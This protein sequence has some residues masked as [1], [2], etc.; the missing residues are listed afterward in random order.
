MSKKSAASKKKRKFQE[1]LFKE[2]E[3]K[4]YLSKI[5][6]HALSANDKSM[7][8]EFSTKPKKVKPNHA[9]SN[10]QVESDSDSEPICYEKD[11]EPIKHTEKP[12]S[13]AELLA[14][15]KN[16]K[17]E[18]DSGPR[19]PEQ[20]KRQPDYKGITVERDF[21][22]NLK[23]LKLPSCMMEQEIV[24]AIKYNDIVLIT[25]D[26]GTGK[27][28]Q[29]PQ[30]LYENG[31]CIGNTIIGV[32][33]IRRVA[34]IAIANQISLELNS[35]ALVGYQVRYNKG[36]NSKSCKI[37]FMTDGI[38]MNELHTDILCSKY[39]VIIIDEAH[40]RRANCDIL[41]GILSRVVKIRRSRYDNGDSLP[42][43]KLVIMSATIRKEDFLESKIF[44][45]KIK[46]LH[47]LSNAYNC[48]IHYSKKT[49][50]DYVIEARDKVAKIH[51][52]LPPGSILVFLTGKDELHRLRHLLFQI[53]NPSHTMHQNHSATH[54]SSSH[55]DDDDKIFELEAEEISDEDDISYNESD[56]DIFEFNSDE[57]YHNELDTDDGFYQ[58]ELDTMSSNYT[59]LQESKWLG[60]DGSGKLK[61]VILHASQTDKDQMEAF[62]I[63]NDNERIV[64]L[65][66]NVAETSVTLPNIRYVVDTGK[67][68]R[69]VHNPTRGVSNF[70]ICNISKSSAQQRAGR[71]GRVGNGHCYRLYSNSIYETLFDDYSPVE[72]VECNLESNLLFLSSIGIANPYD[73]SFLTPPPVENVDIAMKTLATLGAIEVPKTRDM[74]YNTIHSK[75]TSDPLKISPYYPDLCDYGS[76]KEYKRA[77][78]TKLGRC[79]SLIPMEPRY[80]K[81]I[82]C[83]LSKGKRANYIALSFCIVSAMSFSGGLFVERN[84][85]REESKELPSFSNDIDMLIWLFCKYTQRTTNKVEFCNNYN[86]NQKA[87]GEIFLQAIQVYNILKIRFS[88][89][90]LEHVNW[91]EPIKIPLPE[92]RRWLK[93]S[94]VECLIDKLAIKGAY[95]GSK[96]GGYKCS[97]MPNGA[98]CVYLNNTYSKYKYECVVYN[99]LVGDEKI[100][101]RDVLQAN[102]A[103]VSTIKSPLV[104]SRE[105]Q[106]TPV[107][108]Y[109]KEKDVV[110]VYTKKYYAPLNYYLNVTRVALDHKHPLSIRIFAQHFCFGLVYGRIAE[111]S[112][113]LAVSMD[114]FLKPIKFSS[115]IAMLLEEMISKNIGNKK[116]FEKEYRK[117]KLFLF[118][119]YKNL[120]K[121]STVD[122]ERLKASYESMVE[123]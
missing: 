72:I 96:S 112:G 9:S 4:S 99:Y 14:L 102:I 44:D 95:L 79:L 70:V 31:F 55:V 80:A 69:K 122:T 22:I 18:E 42:P 37:K 17:K 76:L 63:P 92:E 83:T 87:I 8:E 77:K 23:R 19:E 26:T 58:M 54:S 81:M 82:Y 2:E 107:P 85:S 20:V 89:I 46:S 6:K 41:I 11:L 71:A 48:T 98:E 59:K 116:A 50:K 88:D 101:M 64:I 75:I 47:V 61:I 90:H 10:I 56:N 106:E 120:L 21:N 66:T 86:I 57:E 74:N 7:I 45:H 24:D 93:E 35:N 1:I 118:D 3:I 36:Y 5:N 115:K 67:E 53:N 38:L 30:F 52:I 94:I 117:N 16:D 97:E 29:I 25:G 113:L 78:I 13:T 109:N 111:Y 40:E 32:T 123:L 108:S 110:E 51:K 65:S 34:C 28:T 103:H 104:L 39:S 49:P 121:E 15:L 62:A 119:K 43:L 68:K 84:I 114:D 105:I 60:S 73:F 33:Q 12:L 91:D 27:S 100:R